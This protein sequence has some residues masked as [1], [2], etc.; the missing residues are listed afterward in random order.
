MRGIVAQ[1]VRNSVGQLARGGNL[2]REDISR[3]A[4][5][6]HS[7]LPSVQNSI[8]GEFVNEAHIDYRANIENNYHSLKCPAYLFKHLLFKCREE[9]AAL[10]V[11]AVHIFARSSAD[12]NNSS[13]RN[14]RSRRSGFIIERHFFLRPRLCA[15]A[16][17]VIIRIFLFPF[18]INRSEL[19]VHDNVPVLAKSVKDTDN[20]RNVYHSART[21]AAFII[22]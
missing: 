7:A 3:A 11:L 22:V 13:V 17:A 10:L 1:I 4:S 16:D 20:A 21:R 14:S 9:I 5:A 12:D 2:A 19:L 8:G 15:P 18:G 6:D